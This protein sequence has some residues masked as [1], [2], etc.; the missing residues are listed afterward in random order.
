M[1]AYHDSVLSANIYTK[2]TFRK[3]RALGWACDGRRESGGCKSGITGFE[4]TSG[5]NRFRCADCDYD[6]CEACY[7]GAEA[8]CIF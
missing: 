7:A 1:T 3:R 8:E 2:K 6:L 4:Q 5:M